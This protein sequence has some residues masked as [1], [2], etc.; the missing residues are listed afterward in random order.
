MKYGYARCSTN[1]DMQDVEYQVRL[2]KEFGAIDET[3]Y[4]EY[5]SGTKRNRIE[6][7]RLLEKLQ[8]HDELYVTELSRIS[9][10]MKDLLEILDILKNKKIKV[11]IGSFILDFRNGDVDPMVMG[12]V[13]MMGVFAQM[14]RDLTSQRV[15]M[16]QENARAKGKKIGR[17]RTSKDDIPAIFLK[18]YPQY[19]SKKINKSEFA[20]LTQ[21]SRP[22]IDKY[23]KIV[24][25]EEE[26]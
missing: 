18:Y 12:M 25:A 15:K 4:K 11:V 6:L 1:E 17:K 14:E 23:I 5:E 22:S 16:G 3:I 21:L 19:I 9:R 7:N 8:S 20:K 10:S 13:S 26:V 2:L 24:E